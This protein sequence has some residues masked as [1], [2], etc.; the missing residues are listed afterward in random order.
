MTFAV[1]H[2]KKRH[3]VAKIKTYRPY[4]YSTEEDIVGVARSRRFG[5]SQSLNLKQPGNFLLLRGIGKTCCVWQ[6]RC[7]EPDCWPR[8]RERA[9]LGSML[10]RFRRLG[11]FWTPRV[12]RLP[13]PLEWAPMFVFL[14]LAVAAGGWTV[15]VCMVCPADTVLAAFPRHSAI[16]DV[17]K[18]ALQKAGLPSVLEPPGLD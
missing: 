17:V 5:R 7:V 11:H 18:R 6:T 10:C 12:L 15:G 13:L 16:N 8:H 2:E 9:G 4:F 1:I 14:I 3:F